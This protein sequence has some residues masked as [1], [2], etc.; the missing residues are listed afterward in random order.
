MVGKHCFKD[1]DDG[2][3]KVVSASN[4]SSQSIFFAVARPTYIDTLTITAPFPS[5]PR[6]SRVYLGHSFSMG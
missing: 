2:K 1:T 4:L 6:A 5:S 3:Q